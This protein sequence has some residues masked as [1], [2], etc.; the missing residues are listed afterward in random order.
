MTVAAHQTASAMLGA[1]SEEEAPVLAFGLGEDV[2]FCGY[3]VHGIAVP[4]RNP[5][6]TQMMVGR[7]DVSEAGQLLALGVDQ[8]HLVARG[9]ASCAVY[10]D[11]WG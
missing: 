6:G 3:C 2:P 11:T 9:V 8:H 4:R 10:P 1:V 5:V 7:E